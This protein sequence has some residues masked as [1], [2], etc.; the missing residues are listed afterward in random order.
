MLK[1]DLSCN[2]DLMRIRSNENHN[3]IKL[4]TGDNH[5]ADWIT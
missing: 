5:L 1:A 2:L 3:D 4:R